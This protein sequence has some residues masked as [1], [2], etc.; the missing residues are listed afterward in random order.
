MRLHGGK[1]ALCSRRTLCPQREAALQLEESDQE[2]A[3]IYTGDDVLEYSEFTDATF[4]PKCDHRTGGLERAKKH[5]GHSLVP[6][7]A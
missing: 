5:K 6:P 2:R 1:R 7:V 4:F 3:V